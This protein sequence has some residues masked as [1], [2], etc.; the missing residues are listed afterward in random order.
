MPDDVIITTLQLYSPNRSNVVGLQLEAR[1]RTNINC[2]WEIIEK[3]DKIVTVLPRVKNAELYYFND[4]LRTLLDHTDSR[5]G[6]NHNADPI[7][8]FAQLQ[9]DF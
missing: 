7:E 5:L 6:G 8:R 3:S 2:G 9:V 1:V 4:A